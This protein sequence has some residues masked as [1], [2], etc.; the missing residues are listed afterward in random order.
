MDTQT[1]E[2]LDGRG[3]I[4]DGRV[5]RG[6]IIGQLADAL[7]A[8]P[9]DNLEAADSQ[10][11]TIPEWRSNVL[12]DPE[13]EQVTQELDMLCGQLL[14]VG[15]KGPVQKALENGHVLCAPKVQRVIA[16]GEAPRRKNGRVLSSDPDVIERHYQV[17]QMAGA[18]KR[19]ASAR[20]AIDM[21]VRRV[22]ALAERRST[23]LNRSRA[24]FEQLLLTDG[25]AS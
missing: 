2:Y 24:Q 10:A 4:K 5:W 11:L 7:R 20:E 25:G 21:T 8:R 14:A 1:L 22:P 19:T 18:I 12:G 9:A 6:G 23:L 15:P 3:F 13:N 16:E 17:P